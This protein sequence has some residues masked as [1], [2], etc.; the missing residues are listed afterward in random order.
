M[1]QD[2][3]EE[4]YTYSGARGNASARVSVSTSDES[5]TQTYRKYLEPS[6]VD[7]HF[8]NNVEI[9]ALAERISE[10]LAEISRFEDASNNQH[11]LE[12]GAL[13][14]WTAETYTKE[15]DDF[16]ADIERLMEAE[17]AEVKAEFHD[18]AEAL[19]RGRADYNAATAIVGVGFRPNMAQITGEFPDPYNPDADLTGAERRAATVVA[20]Y[21]L[22]E[23]QYALIKGGYAH[24]TATE[25]VLALTEGIAIGLVEDAVL[26][27]AGKALKIAE[28]IKAVRMSRPAQAIAARYSRLTGAA[29]NALNRVR[30]RVRARETSTKGPHGETVEGKYIRYADENCPGVACRL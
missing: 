18:L 17:I 24:N 26:V 16:V 3:A 23:R 5:D 10:R 19:T 12:G 28:I 4:E 13:A 1:P 6:E 8:E 14:G 22:M 15:F 21:E 29:R 2:I 20:D 27:G 7:L 25:V 30:A 11:D 9:L